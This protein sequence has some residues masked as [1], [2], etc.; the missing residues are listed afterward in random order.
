MIKY[1]IMCAVLVSMNPF[2]NI[3]TS[4]QFLIVY[5]DFENSIMAHLSYTPTYGLKHNQKKK[6]KTRSL[7]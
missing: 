5:E 1:E 2:N 3:C 7:N 4:M 6:K